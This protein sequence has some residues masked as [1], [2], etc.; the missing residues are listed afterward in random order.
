[1]SERG[2]VPLRLQLGGIFARSQA[3]YLIVVVPRSLFA[4]RNREYALIRMEVCP[5][6][7]PSSAA[8]WASQQDTYDHLKSLI[9][10]T[11]G[12]NFDV[13]YLRANSTLLEE[14]TAPT[15]T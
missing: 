2:I 9:L 7:V 1:M 10:K 14:T 15:D 3:N 13:I 8:I 6:G 12:I 4:S 11:F 5:V